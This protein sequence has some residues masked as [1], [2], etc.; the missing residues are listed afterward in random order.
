MYVASYIVVEHASVD[1]C[2]P[3][4]VAMHVRVY[5]WSCMQLCI[6]KSKLVKQHG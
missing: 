1:I 2:F 6:A 4:Y 5:N 3:I